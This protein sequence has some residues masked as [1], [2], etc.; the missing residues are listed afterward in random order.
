MN[1]S[2]GNVTMAFLIMQPLL[3]T[4]EFILERNLMYANNVGKTFLGSI[5]SISIS[6][7]ILERNPINVKNVASAFTDLH[8]LKDI[9]EFTLNRKFDK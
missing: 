6:L 3:H 1:I 7:F 4:R 8:P 2:V 5:V 9:K